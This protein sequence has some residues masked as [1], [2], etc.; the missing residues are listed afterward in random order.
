MRKNYLFL[1][2]ALSGLM[3]GNAQNLW[4]PQGTNL[5]NSR[6]VQEISIVNATT[7]WIS[8]YDG[9]G[10]GA[11]PKDV[12]KTTDGNSW[13]AMTISNI[14]SGALIS[15]IA[16]VSGQIAYVATAPS[17]SNASHNGI[18]K[19]TDGG[20][21]WTKYAGAIFNNSASFANHVYFWDENNGYCG[22]DPANGKFEMYKTTDGGTTWTAIN[23][24]P[25]PLNADEFTYTGVKKVVGDKIWLGTSLGRILYSGD[26]GTTW[27]AFSSPA[28]DFG[29]VNSPGSSASFAFA[30]NGKDGLLVTDDGGAAF[31]WVTSDGGENWDDAFPDGVWF[32]DDVAA[33][34]GSTKTFVTSGIKPQG[35]KGSS[36]SEDGGITWQLIDGGTSGD[37]S[38][39]RG[40]LAFLDGETG[41]C[42]GFSDGQGGGSGIF[43]FSG[44]IGDLGVA[45]F[46]QTK[47]QVYPNPATSVVNFSSGKEIK[48]VSI[49]DMTGKVVLQSKTTQ[50]DV[51]ALAAGVYIAQ[52]RYA[53]GAAQN[54]KIVVK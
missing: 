41:W 27:Q 25:V 23:T 46:D 15:D 38:G 37:E 31:L 16:G 20:A 49:I 52:V 13:T 8:S 53:D 10:G 9:T 17:G 36:Y 1:T 42:G 19:T 54:T 34:P 43:K 39:Q 51:S 29:G 33:V 2:M 7:A 11:Y 18:W 21:N 47:L 22:G 40:T 50:A 14:P 48:L 32:P 12:A 3:F 35:L 6:G 5:S 28:L 44:N 26:R 4:L 45:D 24:A 30:D